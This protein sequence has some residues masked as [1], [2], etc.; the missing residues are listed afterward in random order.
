MLRDPQAPATRPA[1]AV[2]PFLDETNF[3]ALLRSGVRP[4]SVRL[5]VDYSGSDT[6]IELAC[7]QQIL[8]AGPWTCEI[9]RDGQ[10]L[11]LSAW[12]ASC[13]VT[14]EDVDFLELKATAG[15]VVVQRQMLVPR[16]DRIVY[17]ADVVLGDVNTK[18]DHASSFQLAGEAEYEPAAETT[19]G[20]ILAGGINGSVLPLALPEW[21]VSLRGTPASQA[22][23]SV[24][25]NGNNLE[26]RHKRQGQRLYV[27]LFLGLDKKFHCYEATWRQLTVGQKRQIVSADDAVGYRA[28]IG[29]WQWLIYRSLGE[30]A[31]RTVLGQNPATEFLFGRLKRNGNVDRWLEVE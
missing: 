2:E 10:P 11:V 27:P 28:T 29:T 23:G 15:D 12:E 21:R 9:R 26:L 20:R 19:D 4:G 30:R 18:W 25:Q 3:R 17:L 8:F 22:T 5:A 24:E 6:Q 31:I 1:A 16:K 14:D 13:W 7:G